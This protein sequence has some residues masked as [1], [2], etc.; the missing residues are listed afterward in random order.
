MNTRP[1]LYSL[2]ITVGTLSL[3]SGLSKGETH[4]TAV[5]LK[6]AVNYWPLPPRYAVKDISSCGKYAL[7][8][9]ASFFAKTY[10]AELGAEGLKIIS[11]LDK[12]LPE[13]ARVIG[14]SKDGIS[15]YYY[16][17][18]TIFLYNLAN[19]SSQELSPYAAEPIAGMQGTCFSVSPDSCFAFISYEKKETV[20]GEYKEYVCCYSLLNKKLL[21]QEVVDNLEADTYFLHNEFTH[22]CSMV[23]AWLQKRESLPIIVIFDVGSGRV[24]AKWKLDRVLH[25]LPDIRARIPA[26]ISSYN[27]TRVVSWVRGDRMQGIVAIK[28]YSIGTLI[29]SLNPKSEK[30]DWHILLKNESVNGLDIHGE[31]M[32]IVSQVGPVR[33]KGPKPILLRTVDI[34]TGSILKTKRLPGS[35]QSVGLHVFPEANTFLI[36]AINNSY[37]EGPVGDLTL[38]AFDANSLDLICQHT[39]KLAGE[40]RAIKFSP[41]QKRILLLCQTCF[42]YYDLQ[43]KSFMPL[44]T[45][46]RTWLL[47]I[48]GLSV[49]PEARKA[50]VVASDVCGKLKCLE[51]NWGE[52]GCR[53]SAHE[54]QEW[55]AEVKLTHSPHWRYQCD[56]VAVSQYFPIMVLTTETKPV[57][58]QR[59]DSQEMQYGLIV[60]DLEKKRVISYHICEKYLDYVT[61]ALGSNELMAVENHTKIIAWP[62]ERGIPNFQRKRTI[63]SGHKDIWITHFGKHQDQI[64]LLG[65]ETEILGKKV[66]DT[67]DAM[68]HIIDIP[69]Q[70]VIKR[71]R[72]MDLWEADFEPVWLSRSGQYLVNDRGD[73]YFI[74]RKRGVK[75]AEAEFVHLGDMYCEVNGEQ[76]DGHPEVLSFSESKRLAATAERYGEKMLL[77]QLHDNKISLLH[78]WQAHDDQIQALHL[79]DSGNV[80]LT[81]GVDGYLKVW[82]IQL[83]Q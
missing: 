47:H 65:R 56:S 74:R 70:T 68:L 6:G 45:P 23:I 29:L 25:S 35:A 7:V 67:G 62:C 59:Y 64:V 46:E 48:Y 8:S 38:Y 43:E 63:Y 76:F 53:W 77:F 2:M 57:D 40:V 15:F 66:Y 58:E 60:L 34:L 21:W 24:L 50:Y 19:N 20:D 4:M 81:V 39:E 73:W 28:H 13:N 11:A 12:K 72:A 80:L 18:N 44:W 69:R 37:Y 14:F 82:A 16:K 55:P 42:L 49:D 61:Y 5:H 27:V 36:A 33:F 71:I 17:M 79:H 1:M 31:K 51:I 83:P 9:L 22:D 30:P 10:L 41:V 78:Y 32:L 75:K 52:H 26:S 3:A 54:I